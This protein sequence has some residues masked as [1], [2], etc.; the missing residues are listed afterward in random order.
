MF[1]LSIKVIR[2]QSSLSTETTLQSYAYCLSFEFVLKMCTEPTA[3]HQCSTTPLVGGHY[4][5]TNV[6]ITAYCW[7]SRAALVAA[8]A[9][10]L[11]N[12]QP[13]HVGGGLTAIPAHFRLYCSGT[14]PDTGYLEPAADSHANENTRA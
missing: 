1:Q 12:E 8:E 7:S 4:N 9:S 14:G 10:S 13:A 2:F 6:P 11:S 3:E 5:R